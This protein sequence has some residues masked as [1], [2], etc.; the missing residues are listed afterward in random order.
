M[1][2]PG[3][4][5]IRFTFAFMPASSA[6]TSR[7]CSGWSLTPPS[8]TYSKVIHSRVLSGILAQASSRSAI[9][10]LRVIGMIASRTRSLLAFSDKA[11]LGRIVS[12]ANRS[13]P[14]RM[15]DV[16]TVIRD[17]GMPMP[18]TSKRTPSINES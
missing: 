11:S 14:G 17:S 15:P 4:H 5:T 1:P 3:F 12:V 10:H 18:S 7:A 9:F 13:M 8:S 6:S 2:G 16:D